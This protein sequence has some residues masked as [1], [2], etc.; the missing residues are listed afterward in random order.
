MRKLFVT[1][2]VVC[3]VLAGVSLV[4]AATAKEMPENVTIADCQAKQPSVVFPHAKHA[5]L[6]CKACH[7]TQADLK[8]GTDTVVQKC[9]DCHVAPEKATTPKCSEMGMTKN[10]YHISCVGCHKAEVAKNAAKPLPVKCA[11]CHKKG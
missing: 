4:S 9:K 7:H 8:A 1:L 11:D 6:D 5:A 10:P 2:A 3:L